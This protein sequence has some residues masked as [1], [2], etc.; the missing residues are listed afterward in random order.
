LKVAP[1]TYALLERHG[2]ALCL[3]DLAGRRSPVRL[4]ADFAYVRLHGPGGP[5]QGS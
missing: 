4:T 1:D 2:A 3:W 5:Y